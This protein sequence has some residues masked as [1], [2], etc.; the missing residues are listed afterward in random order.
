M[1]F[2][3]T[4]GLDFLEVSALT[5]ANVEQAFRRLI[6]SVAKLLPDVKV[7]LDLVGLPEGWLAAYKNREGAQEED[8]IVSQTSR[9]SR[10]VDI[11]SAHSKSSPHH[12]DNSDSYHNSPIV[13]PRLGMT[14]VYMNYW[15]GEETNEKP[16][17]SAPTGLIYDAKA[18]D[19]AWKRDSFVY[20]PKLWFCENILR[21]SVGHRVTVCRWESP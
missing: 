16:K 5:G 13:T 11:S 15:T 6:L 4:F 12:S 14:A 3:E 1:K 17:Q 21:Y 10:K 8:A 19:N 18:N 9:K 20:V 2:A 7:H